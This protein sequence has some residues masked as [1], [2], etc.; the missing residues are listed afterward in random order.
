MRP[1]QRITATLATFSTDRSSM[2]A[3][4]I[5]AGT[6]SSNHGTRNSGDQKHNANQGKQSCNAPRPVLKPKQSEPYRNSSG[7]HHQ[8]HVRAG[9]LQ[10]A[11]QI[12]ARSH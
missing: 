4:Q 10:S 9:S 12:G 7:A 11:E 6:K 5:I 2:P 3:S 1:E 8:E